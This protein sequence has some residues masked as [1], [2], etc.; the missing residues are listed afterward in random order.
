[1]LN[2]RIALVAV[3]VVMQLW[4]LTVALNSWLEGHT[5]KV[6]VTLGSQALALAFA[7]SLGVWLAGPRTPLR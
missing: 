1:M 3:I 2:A 4:A 5:G 7:A 6:Y